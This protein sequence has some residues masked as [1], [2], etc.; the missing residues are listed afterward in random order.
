[1]GLLMDMGLSLLVYALAEHVV[2]GQLAAQDET[3]PDQLG[4]PTK[5]PTM[6]RIFQMFDGIDL[7]IVRHGNMRLPQILNLRP[8]HHQL[9]ALLGASCAAILHTRDTSLRKRAAYD[10]AQL[11]RLLPFFH[12][13]LSAVTRN[14]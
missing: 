2:R 4:K 6:R 14:D 5:T 11:M 13:H 7:L 9:L 8:I 12:S 10:L 1:M 3:I